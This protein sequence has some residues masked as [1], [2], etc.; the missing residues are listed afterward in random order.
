MGEK[1][2][3]MINEK[4]TTKKQHVSYNTGNNEWHTPAIYIEAAKKVFGE[5]DLDPASSEDAN[6]TICAKQI[7]TIHDD[8]LAQRWQGKV[9]MNPPYSSKLLKLFCEKLV[10]HYLLNDVTEAIIL[11]NNA[12]ETQWF[13]KLI[14]H[15]NAVV[16]HKGR[17]RFNIQ[18]KPKG[19]PLQGQVF[20]YLGENVEVFLK[21]FACFGWGVKLKGAQLWKM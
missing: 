16:F 11:V 4:Q 14:E 12:T 2:N 3:N 21:H 1:T 19:S 5:I 7:Y 13:N 15:A 6:E 20:I 10:T 17:I 8:G 18:S 9:W